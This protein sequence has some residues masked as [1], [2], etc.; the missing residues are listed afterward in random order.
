MRVAGRRTSAAALAG[1][2]AVA[3]AACGSSAGG[4]T[5]ADSYKIG[6]LVSQT[7]PASQLG[8]GELRGAR[9]AAD[10]LNAGGGVDG[11]KIQIVAIDDQTKPDQDVQQARQLVSQKVAA[12]VGPSVV[13]GCNAVA[14][15]V[16]SRGPVEYCLS[17]G[18]K[19]SGN[20]WSAS[21]K[22]DQLAERMLSYWKGQGI[23]KVGLISTTDASG[24]DGARAVNEA[25]KKAGV[26]IVSS[27][28]YDPTAVSA[29]SQLQQVTSAHPQAI[30]VWSTGTP[31]GVALKGIQQLGI[32]L[33]VA[34]TDGNLSNTFLQRIADYTPQQLLIPATR[35]FWWQ[36]LP[37][38][39]ASYTLEQDYHQKYQ[40]KY[41]EAPDFGPGV[42]YD[43]VLLLAE[44]LKKAG[45]GDAAKLK[46]ALEKI[47]GFNGVV[48]TYHMSADD[49]RG[50]GLPDV[51]IVQAK[52]GAFTYVGR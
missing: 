42:G 26:Q 34:T 22:T 15:L 46:A 32:N 3:L 11:H 39:D 52:N 45:A 35:D 23:T 10:H 18:I 24:K 12:I 38:S 25:A 19:P 8:V 29:T 31:A 33:P 16:A 7:G 51:A 2:T 49:H 50:L 13:A 9:L 44:G 21:V 36:T 17:P 1:L 41:N 47:D 28:D 40:A 4:S 20:V 14:P 5:G 48:G 43:A 6:V 27:A 30:V 37:K